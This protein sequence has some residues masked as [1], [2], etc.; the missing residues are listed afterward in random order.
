M[1]ST[2]IDEILATKQEKRDVFFNKK[3]IK[4]V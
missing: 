2:S 3:Q 1:K 4:I